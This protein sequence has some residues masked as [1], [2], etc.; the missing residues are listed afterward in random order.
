MSDIMVFEESCVMIE[1]FLVEFFW[2]YC[3]Q[4][5]GLF[6]VEFEMLEVLEDFVIVVLQIYVLIVVFCF[7]YVVM[8]VV[9]SLNVV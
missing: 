9:S 2:Y 1:E 7:V 3:C 4:G 6:V 5:Y 8:V